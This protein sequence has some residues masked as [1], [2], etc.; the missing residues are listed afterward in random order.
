MTL[1][2]RPR[3]PLLVL[4]FAVA[5]CGDDTAGGSDGSATT[6][7]TG[8]QD[9]GGTVADSDSAG[10]TLDST[11]GPT[12][13]DSGTTADDATSGST[14]STGSEDTG[15]TSDSG[16]TD[17][18]GDSDGSESTGSPGNVVYTAIALPGG[19]DR[20]RIH[21]ADLDNDRCTWA[22]LVSPAK[23][24]RFP[25]TTPAGWAIESASIN[26]VAAAC[27]ADT[28]GMFGAEAATM[29]VGSVAFGPLG[30]SGIYP[31]TVD[32]DVDLTFAGVL[33]GIPP[34]DVMDATNI[35]VT[36]C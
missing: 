24:S 22:V 26:D 8:P 7:D 31:C 25:I 30:V 17:G 14:G 21:K 32:V 3:L 34:N 12:L 2:R 29:G 36:G 6:S 10:D 4:C 23:F 28:P 33:P 1:N 13:A 16:D 19:L 35:A 20:I 27:D 9:T 15:D 18:S 11:Q 5:S